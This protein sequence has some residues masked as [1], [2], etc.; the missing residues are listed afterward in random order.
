MDSAGRR[1]VE[2][3]DE[4]KKKIGCS[5]DDI[6]ALNLA[7]SPVNEAQCWDMPIDMMI[8]GNGPRYY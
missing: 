4:T 2:S 3:K 5:P 8:L 6:D 7:Y 1:V